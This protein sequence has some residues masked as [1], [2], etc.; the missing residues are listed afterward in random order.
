[1]VTVRNPQRHHCGYSKKRSMLSPWL[2]EECLDSVTM[3][4]VGKSLHGYSIKH[5]TALYAQGGI[6]VGKSQRCSRG[7]SEKTYSAIT[8]VTGLTT[9]YWR[10]PS[11]HLNSSTLSDGERGTCQHVSVCPSRATVRR[12]GS[13]LLSHGPGG[14]A[15]EGGQV[16]LLLLHLQH[17]HQARVPV[18]EE[19]EQEHQ[20]IVDDVGLVALPARVHV[21]GQAGIAQ[22][23]PLSWG[24]KQRERRTCRKYM[25][26]EIQ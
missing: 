12:R 6:T 2:Q 22:G 5:T 14:A 17:Q 23:Q 9:V 1:M 19:V 7:Y 10:T 13:V 8:V 18:A 26:Y 15:A 25:K 24:G 16:R 21:D 3:V 4:T 11:L 20:E